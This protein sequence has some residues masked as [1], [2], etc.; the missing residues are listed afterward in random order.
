[1]PRQEDEGPASP[2]GPITNPVDR[3]AHLPERTRKFLET[4]DEEDVKALCDLLMAYQRAS[5]IGW[6]FKWLVVTVVGAYVAAVAF[7]EAIHKTL[8][9]L[10]P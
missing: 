2:F 9:W 5:T 6:F 3:F 8:L 10:R 1:M 4:L 7:G